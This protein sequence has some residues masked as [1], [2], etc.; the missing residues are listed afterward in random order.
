MKNIE[1][2]SPYEENEKGE[3]YLHKLEL[4]IDGQNIGY[5]KLLY[6][7]SPFPFYYLSSLHI[8]E[9][10]R[11]QGNGKDFLASIKNFLDSKGKCGILMNLIQKDSP[12]KTMYSKYGWQE[13]P[14]QSGWYIYNPPKN[15]SYGQVNKAIYDIFQNEMV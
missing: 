7:N 1:H 14:Y 3:N 5:A 9:Q 15:L 12:A 2:Y 13:I 6:K 8:Y 11:G 10:Y 4:I